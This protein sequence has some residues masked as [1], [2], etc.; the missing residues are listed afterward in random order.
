MSVSPARGVVLF[1]SYRRERIEREKKRKQ[2]RA[3]QSERVK[4]ESVCK[5]YCTERERERAS[6]RERERESH[7]YGIGRGKPVGDQYATRIPLVG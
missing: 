7:V 3:G 2:E 1:R 4:S 5:V 6:E